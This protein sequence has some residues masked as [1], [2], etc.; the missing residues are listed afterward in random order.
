MFTG[1]GQIHFSI[2]SSCFYRPKCDT[3]SSASRTYSRKSSKRKLTTSPTTQEAISVSS[4]EELA[5]TSTALKVK[6][7][8]QSSKGKAIKGKQNLRKS[9]SASPASRSTLGERIC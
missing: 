4:E 8:T 5:T 9:S 7:G 6:G 2:E 1:F 3:S